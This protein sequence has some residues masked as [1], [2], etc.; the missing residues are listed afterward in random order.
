MCLPTF[1][2]VPIMIKEQHCQ[3]EQQ[4][5]RQFKSYKKSFWIMQQTGSLMLFTYIADMWLKRP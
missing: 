2:Y 1:P 4:L 3:T 5:C